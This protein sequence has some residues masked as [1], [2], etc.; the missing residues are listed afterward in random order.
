MEKYLIL[1]PEISTATS[2]HGG[3]TTTDD[4]GEV[5]E[6]WVDSCN[7]ALIHNEFTTHSTVQDGREAT[8]PTVSLCLKAMLTCGIEPIPHTQFRTVIVAHA[9]PFRRHFNIR[10]ADRNGY[11]TEL[12]KLIEDDD[13]IPENY[14]RFAEK[15]HA[16]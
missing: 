10:R 2:P 13:L 14:S 11:S 15:V 7:I 8:T 16:V 5:V 12:D 6:Q 1:Q 9:S 3:Y 4:N